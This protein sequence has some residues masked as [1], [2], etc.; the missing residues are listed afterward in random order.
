MYWYNA[1]RNPTARQHS[2][3]SASKIVKELDN[4]GLKR[5]LPEYAM[6]RASILQLVK[7]AQATNASGSLELSIGSHTLQVQVNIG[8]E[9]FSV[10]FNDTEIMTVPYI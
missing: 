7:V 8:D 6:I 2:A 4:Y 3:A 9:Q 10:V 1:K 5:Y